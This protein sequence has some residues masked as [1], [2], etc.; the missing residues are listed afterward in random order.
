MKKYDIFISYRSTNFAWVEKL[1]FNLT[2]QGYTV[3]LDKWS[4]MGGQNFTTEIALAI[5]NSRFGLLVASPDVTESGWIQVEYEKMLVIKRERP[6]YKLIPLIQGEFPDMPFLKNIHCIDFYKSTQP[7]YRSAFKQL[8]CALEGQSPGANPSFTGDLQFPVIEPS[9]R[10]L[11]GNERDFINTVYS[12]YLEPSLPLMILAQADTCTQHY[13]HAIY[14]KAKQRYGSDHAIHIYPPVSTQADSAAYFGRIAKQCGLTD[15]ITSSWQWSEA[16]SDKLRDHDKLLLLISGFENGSDSAR[17]E[18]AGELRGLLETHP[19]QLKLII[20]GGERLAA[21]KYQQSAHSLL[22]QLDEQRIPHLQ[23]TDLNDIYLHRFPDLEL[24]KAE[25]QI[26]LD[27]TGQHPRLL[28]AC[29]QALQLGKTNWQTHISNNG[30]LSQLYALFQSNSDR[31]ALCQLLQ[32]EQLGRYMAWLDNEL[33]R[34]LYWQNLI[35]DRN[36]QLV[37]RCDLIRNAGKELLG[38]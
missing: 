37:W 38:C 25:L 28:E 2:A 17:Q 27:F 23:L 30:T 21:L 32:Q 24:S 18:L 34:R 3:F 7:N 20:M 4:L 29:F 5:D 12:D 1:G 13:S 26:M 14:Q 36:G 10:A 35:T 16:M 22:N 19:A 9:M 11:V 6:D 31:E 15:P 8:L 33:L